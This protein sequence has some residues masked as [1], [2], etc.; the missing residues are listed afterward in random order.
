MSTSRRGTDG[1]PAEL[2]ARFQEYRKTNDPRLRNAL[3]SDT[4][5]L[6]EACARRFANRGEPLD[7]LEQV[8][9][10]GL[11]H[12]LD[13]FQPD[14]GRDFLAYAVPTIMG[15]VRRYFRDS[16]WSVKTPRSVK[17]R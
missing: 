15:E 11:L 5:S 14:H 2:T 12:A 6:A 8:A 9:S 3:V 1:D 4:R 10:I 16:A 13:R 7:D 17:D